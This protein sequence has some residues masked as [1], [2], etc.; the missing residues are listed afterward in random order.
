MSITSVKTK[1]HWDSGDYSVLKN[2]PFDGHITEHF[3]WEEYSNPSSGEDI[4]A[5]IWPESLIHAKIIEE[6]RMHYYQKRGVGCEANSWYRT[7]TFN[8]KVG[9]VDNSLH[10]WG[11]ATDL[12]IGCPSNDEWQWCIDTVRELGKKYN[13]QIEIGI[14][15]WGIHIGSHIEVWN[16]YTTVP[17]Y[18]FDKRTKK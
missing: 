14:Y 7:P 3:S 13:T 12:L 9:G 17:V 11:C 8:K 4:I 10:L 18:I 16:P 1:I 15:D 2:I 6:F 5:E